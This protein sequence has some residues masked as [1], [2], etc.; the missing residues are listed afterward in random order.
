M[1][2]DLGQL[3]DLPQVEQLDQMR[4][5]DVEKISRLLRSHGLVV[6]D[7]ADLFASEEQ[8]RCPL[9]NARQ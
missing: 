5:R 6:L 3:G 7:D 2:A 4:A 9:N 8:F 1:A